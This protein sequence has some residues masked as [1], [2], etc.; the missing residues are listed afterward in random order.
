MPPGKRQCRA[1]TAKGERCRNL[2]A[3]TSG[4]CYRHD[5]G[6]WKNPPTPPTPLPSGWGAVIKGFGYAAG[7]MATS[8]GVIEFIERVVKIFSQA[9][10]DGGDRTAAIKRLGRIKTVAKRNPREAVRELEAWV[11]T[12]PPKVWR[13]VKRAAHMRSAVR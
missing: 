4:L 5:G 12:I 6:Q 13:S 10:P 11:V 7:G 8:A 1:R 2:T 9:I 3:N